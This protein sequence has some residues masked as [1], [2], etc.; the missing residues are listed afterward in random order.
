LNLSVRLFGGIARLPVLLALATT[1]CATPVAPRSPPPVAGD[2]PVHVD[3]AVPVDPPDPPPPPGSFAP[4]VLVR[5]GD[6]YRVLACWNSLREGS[7]E[8]CLRLVA[9]GSHV[10][11]SDGTVARVGEKRVVARC[12]PF[13]GQEE[14]VLVVPKATALLAVWPA[15]A[16]MKW[17]ASDRDATP[18]ERARIEKATKG[19]FIAEARRVLEVGPD[20]IG[21]TE[22][23]FEVR[24]AAGG[25]AQS[26]IAFQ[27]GNREP[28]YQTMGAWQV[29]AA[30][31]APVGSHSWLIRR[32][33][34]DG[35]WHTSIDDWDYAGGEPK[36]TGEG[37]VRCP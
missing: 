4:V 25:A 34:A 36:V 10:K 16:P 17:A 33:E 8:E 32:L 24:R 23:I 21:I 1:T 3:V 12:A 20:A 31:R 9:P 18:D 6:V 28:L 7:A 29:L 13:A 14:P 22:N 11:L 19:A 15:D 26:V 37:I 27:D 2:A 30:I 5:A 35:Q